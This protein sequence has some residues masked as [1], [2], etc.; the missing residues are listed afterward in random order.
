MGWNNRCLPKRQPRRQPTAASHNRRLPWRRR[1]KARPGIH[2]AAS[3]HTVGAAAAAGVHAPT[4]IRQRAAKAPQRRRTM[5]LHKRGRRRYRRPSRGNQRR[6]KRRRETH[7]VN[8]ADGVGGGVPRVSARWP[9]PV[10]QPRVRQV[11]LQR[12]RPLSNQRNR[13]PAKR[14]IADEGAIGRRATDSSI[15]KIAEGSRAIAG[16]A[17]NE[18]TALRSNAAS[19]TSAV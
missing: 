19:A 11:M 15:A 14:P 13:N 4:Q 10:P 6:R 3:S 7:R 12:R 16:R 17:R 1:T 8:A 9:P 18:A 5:P 2:Q